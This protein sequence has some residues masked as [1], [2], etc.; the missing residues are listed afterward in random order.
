MGSLFKIFGGGGQ[1]YTPP[2]IPAPP[3]MPVPDDTAVKA[4]KRK[5]LAEQLRR[6]GRAST[7]LSDEST[8]TLGA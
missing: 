3:V 8:D 4:A 1:V 2:P 7:I 6:R 5:S